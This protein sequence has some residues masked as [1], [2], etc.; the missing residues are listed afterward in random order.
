M[1]FEWDNRKDHQ[2]L[3]K[4]GV[5]F[6]LAQEA[7]S[8]PFCLTLSDRMI[9]DEQRFWTVGRV[10]TLTILVDV[11]T[12]RDESGEEVIRIVSARKA[13]ARERR[14]YEEYKETDDP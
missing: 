8:D 1:R 3:R 2:N 10:E 4:H 12:L 6:E 7:F 13:T 14:F 5:S 9:D 11:H